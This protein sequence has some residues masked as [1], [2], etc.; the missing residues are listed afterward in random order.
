MISLQ[1]RDSQ[2]SSTPQLRRSYQFKTIVCLFHH[3]Q[4]YSLLSSFKRLGILLECVNFS[5]FLKFYLF[6][7]FW[8]HWV[9][10]GGCVLFSSCGEPQGLLSSCV[11]G[12]LITVASLIVEHWL[13]TCGPQQL[14][15][16]GSGAQAQ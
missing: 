13:L 5:D 12:L 10:I 3:N 14:R 11:L 16:T 1:S 7:Y 9:F 4:S 8:L 6:T 15:C 2:E